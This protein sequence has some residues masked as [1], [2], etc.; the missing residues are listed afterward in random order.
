[1]GTTAVTWGILAIDC[2][3]ED[4]M[5]LEGPGVGLSSP[6]WLGFGAA[7]ATEMPA[8]APPCVIWSSTRV[9]PVVAMATSAVRSEVA[10]AT[11]TIVRMARPGRRT[12]SRAAWPTASRHSVVGPSLHIVNGRRR[13]SASY[14]GVVGFRVRSH[15]G[16]VRDDQ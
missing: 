16:I 5:I 8:S 2:S 12:S 6:S 10:S 7:A 1:M 3:A 11:A 15:G 4:V 14:Q 13:Q 9:R